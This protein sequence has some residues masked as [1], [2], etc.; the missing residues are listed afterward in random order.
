[1]QIMAMATTKRVQVDGVPLG[2]L[3]TKNENEYPVPLTGVK[4]HV[5]IVDVL[6]EVEVVQT[7]KNL[8]MQPIEA[9]Y[10]FP[11]DEGSAVYYF[12]ASFENREILGI[13]KEIEEAKK[14]YEEALESKQS[15]FLL[16]EKLPDVFKVVHFSFFYLFTLYALY[17]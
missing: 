12:S 17:C 14:N 4:V 13:V 1:M 5:K 3:A 6:A 16:E 2:L 8:E 11:V 7:Y 15:A 10:K 9:I